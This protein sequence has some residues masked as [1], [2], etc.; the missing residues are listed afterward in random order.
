MDI[1]ASLIRS[2]N[3]NL[4]RIAWAL[5]EGRVRITIT[6]SNYVLNFSST[7]ISKINLKISSVQIFF[8][9]Y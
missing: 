2:L 7:V 3:P 4:I 8:V 1:I 6:C 5:D 9:K